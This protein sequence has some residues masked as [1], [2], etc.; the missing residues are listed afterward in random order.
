MSCEH[1]RE[2]L[3]LE[4]GQTGEDSA[5]RHLEDCGP[6]SLLQ[7][8]YDADAAALAAYGA[9]IRDGEAPVG[10]TDAV[11]AE[12]G[13]Q[14]PGAAPL[15]P[16]PAGVVVRPTFSTGGWLS[17][18]A[19]LLVGVSLTFALTVPLDDDPAGQA[20]GTAQVETPAAPAAPVVQPAAAVGGAE[21]QDRPLAAPRRAVP[22]QRRAPRSGVLPVD[23]DPRA[24]Q[25]PGLLLEELLQG[26]TPRRVRQVPPLREGERE[27]S[28]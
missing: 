13:G 18:A 8:A 11:L 3:P 23:S 20:G 27:V 24:R 10:L 7:E 19:A 25:G 15:F 28:F 21:V 2:Q 9:A 17:A 26:L 16:E 14:A 5:R 6:C 4:P 22:R 12:I 1:V